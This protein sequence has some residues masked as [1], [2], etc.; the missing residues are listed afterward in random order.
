MLARMPR[1]VGTIVGC[2]AALLLIAGCGNTTRQGARPNQDAR[3]VLDYTPNAVHAGIYLALAR[4][5]DQSEG[6]HLRAD[7]PA[8]PGQGMALLLSDRAEFAILDIHDLAIAQER[9]RDLVG[10]MAVVQAPLAAVVAQPSVQRP[11]D[12]HGRHVATRGLP[13]DGAVLRAIIAGDGGAPSAVKRTPAR[14]SA[15]SVFLERRVA[16]ATGTWNVEGRALKARRPGTNVFRIERYG[17]P[18]YPELVLTVTRTMLESEPDLVQAVVRA[19]RTGY[20]RTIDDPP[21]AVSAMTDAIPGLRRQGLAAQLN[22]VSPYFTVGARRFGEL[23]PDR[24]ARWAAWEH[25]SG[26]VRRRPDVAR[27]FDA[28]TSRTPDGG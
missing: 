10:V 25:R 8:S 23:D 21:A 20:E 22:A 16:G 13:G 2:L 1:R 27:S 12:L 19:L 14:F 15:V 24:L 4:S 18:P 5:Y 7:A 11:R 3:L 9:G 26:I 6:V 28:A 17:A